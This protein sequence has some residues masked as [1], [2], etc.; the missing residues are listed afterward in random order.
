MCAGNIEHG[1]ART[2]AYTTHITLVVHNERIYLYFSVTYYQIS[3]SLPLHKYVVPS[4]VESVDDFPYNS[5]F[6]FL[7]LFGFFFQFF[8]AIQNFEIYSS[9]F[10]HLATDNRIYCCAFISILSHFNFCS[11]ESFWVQTAIS[12]IRALAFVCDV[13]TFPVYLVLQRPWKRRQLSKRIKVSR[14][15]GGGGGGGGGGDDGC[16]HFVGNRN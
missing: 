15:N 7:F 16:K 9:Y 1:A 13:I 4:S 6:F 2:R 5:F 3:R 11:M 8:R 14:R 10:C 12:A